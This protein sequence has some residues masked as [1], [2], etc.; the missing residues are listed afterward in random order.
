MTM[1]GERGLT[2]EVVEVGELLARPLMVPPYQR[3]YKWQVRHVDQLITDVWRFRSGG[4]YRIGSVVVLRGHVEDRAEIVDGQQR[5]LTFALLRQALNSFSL[6]RQSAP[7]DGFGVQVPAGGREVSVPNL[8]A[9]Y[10]YAKDTFATWAADDRAAFL[11][12]LLEE[13]E[14]LLLGLA[15][16]D[17]AFQLFD[18]QNSRG[19]A[20]YPTDL[21]KAFHIR[22]MRSET[23]S[24]ETRRA[25]VERWEAL[26]ASD[27]NDLFS[28]QLFKIRRW[29]SDRSVSDRGFAS[30]DVEMFKGIR[31]GD[32]DNAQHKWALPFLYARNY[33]DDF[34]QENATL[35]R[36]GVM[37]PVDYPFQIDQPVINGETFF[38]FVSHYHALARAL[39]LLGAEEPSADA[40]TPV[41]E[42][43]ARLSPLRKDRRYAY[44]LNLYDCLLLYYVDRF[45][46]Q[47]I[48]RAVSLIARYALWVRVTQSVVQRRS[49]DNYALGRIPDGRSWRGENLFALLREARHPAEFLRL[50]IPRP[51]LKNESYADAMHFF[52]AG[53]TGEGSDG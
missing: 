28:N 20:L 38:E 34:A 44:V 40:P 17:E 13:C 37:K 11:R 30:G 53:T 52:G 46:E 48:R 49:I 4:R 51:E 14:V 7:T 15:R 43:H 27:V 47:E 45:G 50:R 31:E 2:T 41:R 21:L 1:S 18:S 22:E 39:G 19:R 36:F 35:V 16:A 5:Y 10:A 24:K 26:Q 33:T 32:P 12:F 3:P 25:V 42:M 9:N 23:V 8:Q 29:A 6:E